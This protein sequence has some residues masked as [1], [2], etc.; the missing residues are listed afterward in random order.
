MKWAILIDSVLLL[1]FLSLCIWEWWCEARKHE[2]EDE[3]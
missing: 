1:G 2:S 3:A